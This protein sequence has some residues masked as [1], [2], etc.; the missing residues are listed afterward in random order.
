VSGVQEKR[1]D[2]AVYGPSVTALSAA[3]CASAALTMFAP[4]G[5]AADPSASSP[6]LQRIINAL[7]GT[8]SITETT[9]PS[10]GT[11]VAATHTGTE[12]WYTATGGSTLV[13]ENETTLDNEVAHDTAVIWWNGKAA[14]MQGVWCASINAEGCSSLHVTLSGSDILMLGEWEDQGGRHAWKEQFAFGGSDEFTQTLYVGPPGG[15]LERVSVIR[16]RRTAGKS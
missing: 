10:L 7:Q 4:N 12:V 15:E 9:T 11:S 5:V 6:D 2:G 3:V 8:W 16:A 13:E 14:E 1:A